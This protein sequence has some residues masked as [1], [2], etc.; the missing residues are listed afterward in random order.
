MNITRE[1]T[2]EH[3]ATVRMEISNPDYD[4]KVT[5]VLKDYQHKANIPGFRPG[6][7]PFGLIKKMYGKAIVA[8]E[9]NKLISESLAGYLKDENLEVLGNPLPN[10]E[11]NAS[12]NFETQEA[13]DFYFDLGL[14]PAI[15]ITLSDKIAVDRYLIKIDDAMVDRY[16]EDSRKRF[17]TATHPE[18]AGD[19]DEISGELIEK[20]GE[21]PVE[22]GIR[23]NIFLHP[24]KVTKTESKSQLTSLKKEDKLTIRPLEFFNSAE[25]SAKILGIPVTKAGEEDICFDFIVTDV[26]HI[27]PAIL[28]KEFFIRMYPGK[29]I[30]TE[31]QFREEI[32]ND[33]ANSFL[34]ESDKLFFN[35]ATKKLLE[36]TPIGL[37][38]EFLKRW[39]LE[40]N[41]TK[42]TAED[43]EKEYE[44]FAESTRW[45]MIEN[46]ILMD[47]QVEVKEE[48]VRNYIK[49]YFMKQIL[50]PGEN[51]ELEKRFETL[52]DSVMKNK[53]QV[54]KIYN[55]LY[56]ARLLG[57][58]REKLTVVD[59][60]VTYKE[61]ITLASQNHGH[62]HDHIHEHDH[63]HE[64][65]HDH[66]HSHEH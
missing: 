41:E 47:N 66:D 58:F 7:V 63:G 2:G 34:G 11:K 39:L 20:K 10:H 13:F 8:D 18:F 32:R 59:H 6:K 55:E 48:D 31:E 4:G 57:L 17:G 51:P 52:V 56:N 44:A 40:S 50:M 36:E 37:P 33:A 19:E 62:E 30:E 26:N 49:S 1:N 61:F 14:A 38:D 29:E 65:D 35:L 64:H 60:E 15:D 46:K 45:Q 28:D 21:I 5:K 9:I 22:N 42:I 3:T 27:E 12:I 25:D 23:K 54:R 43:I 53:E 16:V 24:D